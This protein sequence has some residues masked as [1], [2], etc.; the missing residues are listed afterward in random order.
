MEKKKNT[1]TVRLDKQVQSKIV[2]IAEQLGIT[3]TDLILW[4]I[5]RRYH[6]EADHELQDR[7][8][9]NQ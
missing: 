3:T 6:H 1:C 4:I 2:A 5:Y 9:K 8:N 7:P